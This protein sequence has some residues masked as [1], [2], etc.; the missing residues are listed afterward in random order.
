M[1]AN[2][3]VLDFAQ[4]LHLIRTTDSTE[5]FFMQYWWVGLSDAVLIE[6]ETGPVN[7]THIMSQ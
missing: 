5:I 1:L 3:N 4:A 2:S 6:W 7:L